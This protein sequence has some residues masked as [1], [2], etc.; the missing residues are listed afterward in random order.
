M[1]DRDIF[2]EGSEDIEIESAS[3]LK[4]TNSSK[5]KMHDIDENSNQH[6]G[7]FTWIQSIFYPTVMNRKVWANFAINQ[8]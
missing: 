8:P 4:I 2:T 5:I 3:G 7:W 6:Y 1:D